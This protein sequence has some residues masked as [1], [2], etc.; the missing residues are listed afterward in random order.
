MPRPFAVSTYLYRQRRLLRDH[1][2][3]IA[4]HGFSAV[5][6]FAS[7]THVDYHN[8]SV[9]ADVQQWLAE[10]RLELT[11]VHA[12]VTETSLASADAAEREAA[13]AETERAPARV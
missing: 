5:E 11:S 10:G 6:L 3:E 7:R 9:V 13:L 12:P 1:L 2:L 8:A 4:A